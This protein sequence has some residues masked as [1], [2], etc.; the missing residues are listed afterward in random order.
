LAEKAAWDFVKNLPN[1]EKFEVVT[2]N[3]GLVLG[4]NLNEA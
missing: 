4:P 2:I 3:P 1:D